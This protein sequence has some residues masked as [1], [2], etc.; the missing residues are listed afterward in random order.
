[1]RVSAYSSPD[2][3]RP[4]P[5]LVHRATR[6]RDVRISKR[7][8]RRTIES[9]QLDLSAHANRRQ[10][11]A[12]LEPDKRHHEPE[13]RHDGGIEQLGH[14]LRTVAIENPTHAILQH[15]G[16]LVIERP[17]DSVPSQAVL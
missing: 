14:Q 10:K 2:P 16:I 9:L 4:S 8:H 5:T 6:D 13:H 7:P 1:M 3:D 12:H 15:T 11:I 17:L